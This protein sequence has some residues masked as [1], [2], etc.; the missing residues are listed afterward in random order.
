MKGD[1]FTQ[2]WVLNML[3]NIRELDE[4]AQ[5]ALMER[6]GRACACSA[7]VESAKAC[8]GDLG[9]F[10]SQFRKWI[11]KSNV[12]QQG[13]TLHLVYDKCYCQLNE[14]ISKQLGDT[15]C[16]CSRGWLME[17]FEVVTGKPVEVELLESIKRGGLRCR[18]VVRLH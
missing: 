14:E 15:H 6:C 17:M 3:G 11:G 4:K 2:A 8:A 1:A 10:E 12:R 9:K 7:S 13:N 16:Y 5:M 18:F